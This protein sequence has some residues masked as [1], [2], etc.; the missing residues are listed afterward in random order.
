MKASSYEIIVRSRATA[1]AIFDLLAD[2]PGWPRWA[3]PLAATASWEREGEPAP[4][5]VGAIRKIGRW[6]QYGREQIVE[7][8][9][10]NHVAYTVLSGVPVRDY[11]AD[12][13]IV[14]EGSGTML[15]WRASF[16]P[17]FPGTGALFTVVLRRIVG[18]FA[19]RAAEFA[20][21]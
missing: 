10:P 17:K 19:R 9:P 18:G 4:G 8:D 15:R 11:R 2:A 21:N 3:G 13:D 6:P 12:V 1:Q 7:Y 5:G 14:P 20:G 16:T